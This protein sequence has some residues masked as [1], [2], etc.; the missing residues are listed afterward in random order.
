MRICGPKVCI[1]I[2]QLC[3]CGMKAATD[4]K[5]MW[6][7][8]HRVLF[9]EAGGPLGLAC[10]QLASPWPYCIFGMIPILWRIKLRYREVNRNSLAKGQLDLASAEAHAL[11]FHKHHLPCKVRHQLGKSG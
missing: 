8:S 10:V 7:G 6:L 4:G 11:N 1:T 3:Q 9:T 2:I 5:W